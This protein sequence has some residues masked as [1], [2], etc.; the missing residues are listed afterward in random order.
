MRNPRSGIVGDVVLGSL[1]GIVGGW[2]LRVFGLQ[3][4]AGVAGQIARELFELLLRAELRRIDK[5]RNDNGVGHPA[6]LPHH[7]EVAFVQRAHRGNEPDR[8]LL[9]PQLA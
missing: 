9:L 1:G 3:Q 8:T 2:L 4:P 6:G 5:D 7:A